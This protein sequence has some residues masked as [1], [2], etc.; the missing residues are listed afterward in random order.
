MEIIA[1]LLLIAG[2]VWLFLADNRKRGNRA[3]RAH[4]YLS[5]LE[6]GKDARDANAEAAATAEPTKTQIHRTFE[7]LQRDHKG[8]Q[9][10]LLKAA[11]AKGFIG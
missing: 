6:A 7:R 11:E 4:I 10:K 8:N 1:G 5:A 2:I 3:V 9:R